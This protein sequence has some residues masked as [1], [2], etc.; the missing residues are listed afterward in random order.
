MSSVTFREANPLQRGLRRFAA[1]RPGAWFFAHV[2]HH[3]DRPIFRMTRGRH[4]L[5]SALAGL[6]IVMLTTIGAK[7]GKPRTVPLLG[8]P[9][10]DGVA[11]IASNFG[12]HHNPAWM[13]NLLAH[14]E[15]EYAI[16]G[17]RRRY[18]AVLAE[19]ERRAAI[20]QQG[21][22]IYPGWSQY[23]RRTAHRDIRVFVLEDA[24]R[25]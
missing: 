2:L 9:V 14:P 18:R 17:V 6:P 22:R 15:G 5:A 3:V 4:T 10:E 1:S 21:L 25:R 20:W 19:G 8:L 11:V 16:D 12:Q 23:E 24:E 13:H 7:S